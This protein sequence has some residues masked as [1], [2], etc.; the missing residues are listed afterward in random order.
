MTA[1]S[2]GLSPAHKALLNLAL[3]FSLSGLSQSAQAL[4]ATAPGAASTAPSNNST[5]TLNGAGIRH[6]GIANLYRAELRLEQPAHATQAVLRGTG[7]KQLRLTVLQDTNPRQLTDVLTLG[8]VANT[9]NDELAELVSEIF[10]LGVLIN[11]HGQFHTG[12]T[13]QIDAH[14]LTGT[15]ITIGSAGNTH[16]DAQSFANPHLFP[17]LLGIWLGEHPVDTALKHSLLGTSI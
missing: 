6:Q 4:D 5:L 9:S 11:E 7:G 10:E 16:M 1:T 15:T 3:V 13:L 17:A 14:P 8:L 2:L 12:D